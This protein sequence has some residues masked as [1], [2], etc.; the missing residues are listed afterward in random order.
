MNSNYY[1][2]SMT[3]VYIEVTAKI[4]AKIVALLAVNS[5]PYTSGIRAHPFKQIP[6]HHE[7]SKEFS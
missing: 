5:P 4:R 1:L 2:Q 3:Q 6:V 7:S